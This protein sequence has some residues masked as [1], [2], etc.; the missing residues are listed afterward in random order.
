MVDEKLEALSARLESLR[1][2]SD[3]L[4]GTEKLSGVKDTKRLFQPP[5]AKSKFAENKAV[6]L[7]PDAISSKMDFAV[8]SV[9]P[10][11]RG[12][13]RKDSKPEEF[14]SQKRRRFAIKKVTQIK[15]KKDK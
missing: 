2:L 3:R 9:L 1:H 13:P 7:A 5:V 10:K 14:A 4:A 15:S 8:D 12:R 6:E 11:K